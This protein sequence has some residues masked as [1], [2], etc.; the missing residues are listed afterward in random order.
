MRTSAF[1]IAAATLALL[2]AASAEEE[3]KLKPG[4]G[5]DKVEANCQACHSL[6]YIPMNSPFLNA[7]GWDGEVTKMIKAFG[8]PIDDGDA[9][10]IADYLKANYG[11]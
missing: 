7:A 3:I 9:K 11:G 10:A 2:G 5:A 1:V 8:A 4:A 6:S